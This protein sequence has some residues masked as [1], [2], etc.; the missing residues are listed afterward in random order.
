MTGNSKKIKLLENTSHIG[1]NIS[2]LR[3]IIACFVF[4]VIISTFFYKPAYGEEIQYYRIKQRGKILGY[5]E[6]QKFSVD[7]GKEEIFL[8]TV[9]SPWSFFPHT[10][11]REIHYLPGEQKITQYKKTTFYDGGEESIDLYKNNGKFTQIL[12]YGRIFYI[13][14]EIP[15]PG[16]AAYLE[17]NSPLLFSIF[18]NTNNFNMEKTIKVKY[19]VPSSDA[20]VHDGNLRLKHNMF[21][22]DGNFSA[23]ISYHNNRITKIDFPFELNSFI[24]SE[25][26]PVLKGVSLI[27]NHRENYQVATY[28]KGKKAKANIPGI[29][30]EIIIPAAPPYNKKSEN[31]YRIPLS[32]RTTDGTTLHGTLTLPK[33]KGPH[34]LFI[35]VPG[36]GPY[37]RSGG[38][39]F[40]I[41]ANKLGEQGIA[42]FRYDKRG[43][44]ESGGEYR[45]STLDSLV[46]DADSAVERLSGRSEIDPNRIGILGHSEGALIAARVALDN[47]KIRGAILLASPSVKMFPDMAMEQAQYF[48]NFS[49]WNRK[50]AENMRKHLES[51]KF[52]LDNGRLWYHYHGKRI[53]LSVLSSF[54]RMPDPRTVIRRIQQPVLL[55]HGINDL[56]VPVRH[57][58]ILYSE[59]QQIDKK[60]GQM[61]IFIDTGH[62]FGDFIPQA[63]SYPNRSYVKLYDEVVNSIIDWI[64]FYY[65][66]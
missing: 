51:I 45:L 17:E 24:Y 39:M 32:F 26:K 54:Y 49:N 2:G 35:L 21:T 27:K 15:N 8:E 40:T 61:R 22:F 19:I 65:M 20:R 64:K 14:E 13:N 37:D 11:V 66:K 59:M 18:M 52:L 6:I 41:L 25:T 44:G 30:K 60:H 34:P 3:K 57:S 53:P 16:T 38:G 58:K 48:D 42:T 36:S 9:Y 31:T 29:R 50:S 62:F 56:I 4:L 5:C 47:P 43:I 63:D 33:W 7:K 12:N 28:N 23:V 1:G 10:I 46:L 55:L